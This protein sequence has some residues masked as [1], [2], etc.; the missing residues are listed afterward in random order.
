MPHCHND[1]RPSVHILSECFVYWYIVLQASNF[2]FFEF[3]PFISDICTFQKRLEQ[4]ETFDLPTFSEE[5]F[6]DI[7]DIKTIFM[8]TVF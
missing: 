8:N 1:K 4:I 5:V 7:M 3:S 2:D 6:E